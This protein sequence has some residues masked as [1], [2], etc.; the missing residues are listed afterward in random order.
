ML[1]ALLI[2]QPTLLTPAAAR[3]ANV[4]RGLSVVLGIALGTSIAGTAGA[5]TV[6]NFT[7][8]GTIGIDGE[9]MDIQ[10]DSWMLDP[11]TGEFTL[12]PTVF[13]TAEGQIT[14]SGGGLVDPQQAFGANVIDFGNPSSFLF[15]LSFG[16]V[17]PNPSGIV[18]I[19]GDISGSFGEGAP[20][21]AEDGGQVT[22]IAGT[23]GIAEWDVNGVIV[24][25]NGGSHTY[26][27]PQ[28][29][30]SYPIPPQATLLFDC[31]TTGTGTCDTFSTR[32]SFIGGGGGDNYGFSTSGTINNV[33]EPA[34]GVLLGLAGLAL[35]SHMRRR[36]S[37]R[38]PRSTA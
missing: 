25:G 20:L 36:E 27:P 18:L 14:F 26:P 15:N 34:L 9:M 22:Q 23:L 35:A 30:Q 1:R 31:S 24:L 2:R 21:G 6:S 32:I 3:W 10:P 16:I 12:M 37:R 33:P 29:T 38:F 28:R 11:E 4:R 7:L 8:T 13:E 19:T 17:L 5:G